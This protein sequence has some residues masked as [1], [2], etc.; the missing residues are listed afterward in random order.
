MIVKI[1]AEFKP[2]CVKPVSFDY[3]LK[4]EQGLSVGYSTEAHKSLS[5]D[6]LDYKT[7]DII[8][9][10][11]WKCLRDKNSNSLIDRSEVD[12]AGFSMIIECV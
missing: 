9:K 11:A 1:L 4:L 8:I 6:G 3:D 2:D 12:L 5:V 10:M 7:T